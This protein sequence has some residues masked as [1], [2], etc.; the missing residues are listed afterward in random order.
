MVVKVGNEHPGTVNALG[1]LG[2]T[3]RR[4]SKVGLQKGESLIR[5]TVAYM[6]EQNYENTHPWMLKYG[7]E[8]MLQQA[9]HLTET[10]K[11]DESF[12]MFENVVD[13]KKADQMASEADLVFAEE[14]RIR[15]IIGKME[16]W[17]GAARFV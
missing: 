17:L 8:Y 16:E 7:T 10:A 1:N 12:E 14:G 11:H 13:V 15:S 4:Q 2:I 9:V 6:Q 3:L 5:E